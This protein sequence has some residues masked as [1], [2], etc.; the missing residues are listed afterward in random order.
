MNGAGKAETVRAMY[1][2][3]L[4]ARSDLHRSEERQ[5]LMQVAG[6]QQGDQFVP[7]TWDEV[8]KIVGLD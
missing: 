1:R 7:A 5:R 4:R 3:Y 2:A 8:R 6:R